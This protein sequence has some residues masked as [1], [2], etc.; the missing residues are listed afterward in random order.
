MA[1]LSHESSMLCVYP[2]APIPALLKR[3]LWRISRFLFQSLLL[4]G[5]KLLVGELSSFETV[6][7]PE[8]GAFTFRTPWLRC[9]LARWAWP[10][11]FPAVLP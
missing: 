6:S 2:E 1:L 3:V 9:V 11:S 10:F 5:G 4:E 8:N 7:P